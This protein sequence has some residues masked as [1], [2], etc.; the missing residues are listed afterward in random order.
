[1]KDKIV[2]GF[3]E[4]EVKKIWNGIVSCGSYTI[5]K[6]RKKTVGLRLVYKD[7]SMSIPLKDFDIRSFKLHNKLI[8]SRFGSPYTMY[9][10]QWDPDP[11]PELELQLPE[12]PEFDFV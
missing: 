5:A 9:D 2:K 3:L 11:L 1:M 10:F 7:R 12:Q 4:H 8:S 6:C